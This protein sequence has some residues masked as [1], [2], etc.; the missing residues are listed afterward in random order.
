[1]TCQAKTELLDRVPR[2]RNRFGRHSPGAISVRGT[3]ADECGLPA[4]S[5]AAILVNREAGFQR[6]VGRRISHHNLEIS[7]RNLPGMRLF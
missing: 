7:G 2:T 6:G 4:N 3:V 1:M 5:K